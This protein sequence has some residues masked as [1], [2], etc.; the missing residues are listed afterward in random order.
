M[1]DSPTKKK[2]FGSGICWEY[3]DKGYCPCD[4]IT[5]FPG[6][7]PR[8]SVSTAKT[9]SA[10]ATA[11]PAVSS[12]GAATVV[13][14]TKR[15]P[16]WIESLRYLDFDEGDPDNFAI[17]NTSYEEREDVKALGASFSPGMKKWIVVR[18]QDLAPFERWKP[19][20]YNRGANEVVFHNRH[21]DKASTVRELQR[22]GFHPSHFDVLGTDGDAEVAR[23]EVSAMQQHQQVVVHASPGNHDH[24]QSSVIGLS[25]D[26]GGIS[27]EQNASSAIVDNKEYRTS[28][29]SAKR[30]RFSTP[31]SLRTFVRARQD[32]QIG[33]SARHAHGNVT[34]SVNADGEG[35]GEQELSALLS[36]A[37]SALVRCI[38]AGGVSEEQRQFNESI[39][40]AVEALTAKQQLD[41]GEKNSASARS[42]APTSVS[43]PARANQ[44]QKMMVTPTR[45]IPARKA[46]GVPGT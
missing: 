34:S 36:A 14:M 15:I 27:Q 33:G 45:S 42:D 20:I 2:R 13:S 18:G 40:N 21:L 44:R 37:K 19:R 28:C 39:Y 10:A 17:L 41:G 4:E 23:R 22:C 1:T 38:S 29:S 30:P 25:S 32:G 3:M 7:H 16:E 11:A 35:G 31:E 5:R 9:S 46:F 8:L 24:G 6:W 26:N 43:S 12:S